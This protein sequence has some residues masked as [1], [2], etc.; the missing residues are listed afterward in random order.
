MAFEPSGHLTNLSQVGCAYRK[1]RRRAFYQR[2][3][4]VKGWVLPM[5]APEALRVGPVPRF[6]RLGHQLRPLMSWRRRLREISQQSP[7]L[8]RVFQEI[9]FAKSPYYFHWRDKP[10]V[11]IV[12]HD[13]VAVMLCFSNREPGD[14]HGAQ[15]AACPRNRHTR[16]R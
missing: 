2:L 9:P 10:P 8:R 14:Q 13:D 7:S 1:D 12:H 15:Q 5:L 11:H 4:S 6:A 3:A 16:Q